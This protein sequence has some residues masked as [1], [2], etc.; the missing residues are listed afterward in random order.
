MNSEARGA[1]F[2]DV[3]T[4]SDMKQEWIEE[5]EYR[6]PALF[7][8]IN[9][10]KLAHGES[11]AGYLTFMGIRLIELHRVL[12]ATGSIYLHCDDAAVHYLK[13]VLDALF[14]EQ[15]YKA[16]ITWQRT[17]AHNDSQSFGNVCDNILFYSSQAR[18]NTQDIRVPLDEDYVSRFYRF[19]DE[20][21][22]YQLGD[23]TAPKIGTGETGQS[24]HGHDPN[25]TGRQWNAPRSGVYAAWIE[26][27]IIPGYRS[28]ASPLARLDALDAAGLVQHPDSKGMPRLK[29][30][31]VGNPGQTPSNLWTDIRPISPHSRERTG[32]RT[33]K[34]LA[35]VERI[36]N[37]SSTENDLV[38]DP[39]CGCATACI[40][41]EKLHRQWIGIDILPQAVVTL[42]NRAKR[43][44]Q[45]PMDDGNGQAWE[46]WSRNLRT[47]AAPPG[48]TDLTLLSPVNPQSEKEFLYANQNRR[49]IGCQYELPLHVLTIDHITPRSRGGLDSVGNLQLMCHT[50]NAIKGNRSMEYLRQRLGELGILRG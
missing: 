43:E 6:R 32:W 25:K 45:I 13:A 10:A 9:G 38:L 15:S 12:K 40:A 23:L 35:L 42:Q 20:R 5:V 36:I 19:E 14:G 46:D 1:E 24:W 27:T 11:M 31:L 3:W 18:I 48:R 8:L 16:Q 17:S 41:A 30:Y 7:Y 29:R 21:G 4:L 44:L 39:F 2:D 26:T 37:A 47:E 34:P 50:C 49:C 33:Q 22:A 28:I